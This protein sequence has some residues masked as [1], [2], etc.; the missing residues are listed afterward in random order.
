M[1]IYVYDYISIIM[2]LILMKSQ[3]RGRGQQGFPIVV[4]TLLVSTLL[5]VSAALV[6]MVIRTTRATRDAL[7]LMSAHSQKGSTTAAR[8][9]TA[10]TTLASLS[11]MRTTVKM[12]TLTGKLIKAVTKSWGQPKRV[13]ANQRRIFIVG[14]GGY[15]A[16]SYGA[17]SGHFQYYVHDIAEDHTRIYVDIGEGGRHHHHD[18][19]QSY[20]YINYQK[21]NQLSYSAMGGGPSQGWSGGAGSRDGAKNGGTM[22][23]KCKGTG[24]ALPDLPYGEPTITPADGGPVYNYETCDWKFSWCTYSYTYCDRECSTT[25][26]GGGGGGVIVNGH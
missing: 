19:Y 5:A 23:P 16:N 21:P 18:G 11:V 12:A 26:K 10:T 14:G 25:P 3:M 2:I 1:T 17:G 8:M 24:A 9:L 7:T 13:R 15:A 6:M 22:S 20:V 4:T